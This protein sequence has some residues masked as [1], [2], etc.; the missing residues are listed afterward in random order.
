MSSQQKMLYLPDTMADW[1]W[2]RAINPH[3]KEI[4]AESDSWFKEFKPFTERSQYA[5][6][7]C[8]FRQ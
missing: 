5:F 3:Y 1:P 2:P 7:K 6:D 8:D 4:G